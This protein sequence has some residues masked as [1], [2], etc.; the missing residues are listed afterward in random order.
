MAFSYLFFL[1]NE[2][3]LLNDCVHHCKFAFYDN[4]SRIKYSCW[5]S[6]WAFNCLVLAVSSPTM[7][8]TRFFLLIYCP[9]MAISAY[10]ATS[11]HIFSDHYWEFLICSLIACAYITKRACI[12]VSALHV[13]EKLRNCLTLSKLKLIVGWC[14]SAY[15]SVQWCHQLSAGCCIDICIKRIRQWLLLHHTSVEGTRRNFIQGK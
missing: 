2:S 6:I 14:C 3:L 9:F 10:Q 8:M 7:P 1:R 5:H 4:K 12:K 11:N 13:L 15:K